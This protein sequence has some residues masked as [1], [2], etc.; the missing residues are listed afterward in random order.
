MSEEPIVDNSTC[1]KTPE[2]LP[3]KRCLL[4]PQN[5]DNKF[6]NTQSH[7]LYIMKKLLKVTVEYQKLNN[8][9]T[10]LIGKILIFHHRNRIIKL[11]K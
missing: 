10:I 8:I 7:F 4:N 6:F 3:L 1:I 2:W 5:N 9:M 11:L